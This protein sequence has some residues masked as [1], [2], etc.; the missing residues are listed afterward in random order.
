MEIRTG[1]LPIVSPTYPQN[2]AAIGRIQK[3]EQKVKAAKIGVRD[4]SVGKN[5]FVKTRV[6]CTASIKSKK[7]KKFPIKTIATDF[8]ISI[9]R[10]GLRKLTFKETISFSSLC[11]YN[12]IGGLFVFFCFFQ[13]AKLLK[14]QFFIILIG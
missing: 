12:I 3:E 10:G 14:N 8:F 9:E 7:S 1:T 2:S 5:T 4:D 11:F 13:A 6:K